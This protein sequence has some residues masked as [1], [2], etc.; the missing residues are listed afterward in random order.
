[1][2]AGRCREKGR[3]CKEAVSVLQELESRVEV[4]DPVFEDYH[5]RVIS[6]LKEKSELTYNEWLLYLFSR[7]NLMGVVTLNSRLREALE[8]EER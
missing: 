1:V 7:D 3:D 4:V 6:L 2:I 5:L 8:R